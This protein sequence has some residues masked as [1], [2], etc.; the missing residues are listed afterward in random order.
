MEYESSGKIVEIDKKITENQ[1]E[2]ELTNIVYIRLIA[3]KIKFH[4][5]DFKYTEFNDSYFRNCTFESCDFTG[6]KF[7]TV[8]FYGA[9]F[10]GCKF[11]YSAFSNTIIS[12]DI[13]NTNCPSWENIKL[14]F[15]RTLRT[16]FLQIGDTDGVNKAIQVELRATEAHLYKAWHSNESYYRNKYK[17]FNKTKKQFEWIKFK[18]MDFIWG[19]GE[20]IGK[21]LRSVFFVILIMTI[22]DVLKYG[23]RDQINSYWISFLAMPGIFLGVSS[24]SYYNSLY[25]SLIVIIRLLT[26]GFF[27]SM[28]IKKFNRR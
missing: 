27:L 7:I 21:L 1:K 8:N 26:I 23:K 22:I 5:V 12:H 20:R 15:A 19:N 6:C 9:K 25:L 11:E 2:I 17:G 4:E 16:N 13:L 24:P 28:I 3:D 10:I 18:I 14:K